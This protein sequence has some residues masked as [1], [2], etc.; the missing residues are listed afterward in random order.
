MFPTG[1]R[2]GFETRPYGSAGLIY[3]AREPAGIVQ[4]DMALSIIGI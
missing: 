3:L 2:G 4:A 1:G